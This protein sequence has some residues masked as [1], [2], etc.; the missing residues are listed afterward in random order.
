M[1]KITTITALIFA[2]QSVYAQGDNENSL[3][4]PE[5]FRVVSTIVVVILFMIFIL[6]II[7]TYLDHRLKNKIID[8]GLAENIAASILQTHPNENRNSNIKWFSLLAGI[9]AGL[10]IVNYTQPLGIHSLAIMSF[11]ISASFLGYYFF[12]KQAEK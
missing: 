3:Y 7:K 5:V 9:G 2:A 11:C 10:T 1:K 6:A 8:K 12:I 4:R